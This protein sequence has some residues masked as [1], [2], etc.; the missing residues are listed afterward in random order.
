MDELSE[1][2]AALEDVA[3]IE[4]L[5]RV[6]SRRHSSANG[7]ETAW[8]LAQASWEAGR[9]HKLLEHDSSLVEVVAWLDP[10]DSPEVLDS[11]RGLFQD[12]RCA[13]CGLWVVSTV[14]SVPCPVCGAACSLT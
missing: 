9:P 1:R 14:K 13:G 4:V 8:L 5:R 6:L 10:A 7:V 12:G 3:L 11:R 2:L